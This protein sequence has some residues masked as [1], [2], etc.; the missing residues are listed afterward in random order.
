[1]GLTAGN[2]DANAGGDLDITSSLTINGAGAGTTIIQANAAPNTATERVFHILNSG[3]IAVTIDGVTIENGH[4][5][6]AADGGRG[7]GIKVGNNSTFDASISFT[8]TNSIIRNNWADTRGGGLA[9]NKANSIITNCSFTGNTAGSN[10]GS[11]GS[12][13]GILIDSQDNASVPAMTSVI[14]NSIIDNNLAQ[15]SVTNT[16]GGGVIVRALNATVTFDGCAITNNTSNATNPSFSAF[17]GGLYN[18]QAHVIIKNSMV[19]SNISSRFHA[20]IRSL[21]STGGPAT[22][23]ISNSTISNNTSTASDAQGGG[24]ANILGSTFDAAT[25]IDHSTISDNSLTGDTSIAGGLLNTGSTG[26]AAILNVTNST[27]SGNSAH[28]IG[29]IYSDGSAATCVIDFT[30]VANNHADPTSGDGGG[31]F[32]DATAGG[33]TFVSNSI[34]AD[35]TASIDVDINDLTQSRDYNH[36]ENPNPTFV[37]AAHDILNSDPG[38]GI[39]ANNGGP[40]Q[41]HLPSLGSVVLNT[42]PNG[43]NGCG[44]PV[45]DDQRGSI[46]PFGGGG[47]CDKGSVEL[48]PSGPTATATVT[49]SASPTP[50]NTVTPPATSTGTST[51]TPTATRTSTPTASP[52][53]TASGTPCSVQNDAAVSII[54]AFAELPLGKVPPQNTAAVITN[55]GLQPLINLPVMLNI[56]GAESFTDQQ[57]IPSLGACGGRATV[58]FTGFTPTVIGSDVVQVSVPNDDVPGNNSKSKPLSVTATSYSYKYAGTATSGGTGFSGNAGVL[59][60]KFTTNSPQSLL[61]VS[62]E[63]SVGTAASYRVAIYGDD[64]GKP[65][66]MPIYVDSFDRNNTTG[67]VT[68]SVSGGVAV[69]PGAFYVGVQQRTGTIVNLGYESETPLRNGAFFRSTSLPPNAWTDM[70]LTTSSKLNIGLTFAA[71]TQT[72]T[73]SPTGS[74]TPCLAA[75]TW[76]EKAPYPFDEQRAA[77]ATDGSLVYVFGGLTSSPTNVPHAQANRYDPATDS[78]SPLAPMSSGADYWSGA[79]YGENGKFYVFGGSAGG[80]LNRIYNIASNT[81]STGAPIPNSVS[82]AAHAYSNGKIYLIGGRSGG[83]RI[84]AVQ[85]YDITS[86][87]W[88]SGAPFPQ[89]QQDMGAGVLNGEIYVAGGGENSTSIGTTAAYKYDIAANS[90]APLVPLLIAANY[91]GSTVVNGRLWIIGGLSNLSQFYDPISGAWSFGPSLNH[92]RSG[93]GSVTVNTAGG[94]KSIFIVGGFDPGALTSLSSVESNTFTDCPTATPTNTQTPTFTPTNTPTATFTPTPPPSISGIVF[95]GNSNAGP[96]YVSD[97]LIDGVGGASVAAVSGTDGSYLLTGFGAG[98]Y[99]VTPSRK[100]IL[101]NG[102]SSFD[103][104]RVVQHVSGLNLFNASQAAAADVSGNGLI[105]SFDASLI[106]RYVAFLPGAGNTGNWTF[107]PTHRTYSSVTGVLA[108]EDYS[109]FL[110]GD[111]SGDWTENGSRAVNTDG[112]ERAVAVALPELS[113]V[114]YKEVTVPVSVS[115]I[116]GKGVISYEFDLRYDPLVILPQEDPVDLSGT[117][118]NGLAAVVNANES[119]L[120]RVVIYGPMPLDGIGLLINLRF[121]VLGAPGSRSPITFE[122]ILFN[123]GDPSVSTTDGSIKVL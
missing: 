78:W 98:S 119:G 57:I 52:T 75:G 1:M 88:S 41:T 46:R 12:G 26:G 66:T 4:A 9:I 51:N 122:R 120:L 62:L 23:D 36:F 27:V 123:E 65:S 38:L 77:V 44:S 32:Q 110:M 60:S 64:G 6:N 43:T 94:T 49:P 114:G 81:W 30:T 90:W 2:E 55:N 68:L 80:N 70:S 24:V 92:L 105:Q 22:L 19:S 89:P 59:V 5:L 15:T 63:F 37:P 13:G 67:P 33:A 102:I 121:T 93:G 7:G 99:T 20:G 42:I 16:F 108:G 50:S 82:G 104:A 53:A 40:T 54:Y 85:I 69:G 28:D 47:A 117:M 29:G 45:I 10:L 115:S 107:S 71:T 87:T 35:N 83:S 14:T 91:P 113:I 111:V 21:A 18:Q 76:T 97:V 34:S 56:T 3:P 101:H 11:G 79:E 48:Q 73:A 8:L 58:T 31:I 17:A 112:P 72:P 95:Y 84:N 118:S 74:P 100:D 96:R 103:A 106:A 25:N 39:L 86:N 116:T 109:A 61:A